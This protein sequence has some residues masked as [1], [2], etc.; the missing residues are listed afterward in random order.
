MKKKLILT[1]LVAF[2]LIMTAAACA[3]KVD[4]EVIS[5]ADG[6]AENILIAINDQDY[7]SYSMDLNDAMLEAVSE[8]EFMK[9]SDYMK[10]TVGEYIQGSKEYLSS[11]IQSG[12]NIVAYT[13]DYTEETEDV[14]I[15]IVVSKSNKD[16][17]EISGTLFN[18]PKLRETEY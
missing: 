4:E 17:Y 8:Q 6:A 14:I 9:F 13:A 11:A 10:N 16:T 1:V 2:I 7:E 5:F 15:T 3:T 12:V 18:S